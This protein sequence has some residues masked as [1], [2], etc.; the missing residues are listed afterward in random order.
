MVFKRKG[1]PR[2]F[3]QLSC[4]ISIGTKKLMKCSSVALTVYTTCKAS[5]V[6]YYTKFKDVHGAKTKAG[7]YES[8]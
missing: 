4:L 1:A 5:I 6:L 2:V 8:C 3:W 7:G